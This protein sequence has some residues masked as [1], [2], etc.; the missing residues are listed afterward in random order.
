MAETPE[1]RVYA[2]SSFLISLYSP[3]ANSTA[4]I[5]A[6]Q[7]S[8]GRILIT[9]LVKLEVINA[10]QQRVFWK[11]IE[12]REARQSLAKFEENLSDGAFGFVHV[13]GDAF[14]RAE[15][16]A[17]RTTARLGTRTI[18]LLHVACALELGATH[19]Y[20]FDERQRK[21]AQTMRLKL[22]RFRP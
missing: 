5:A 14:D 22:N 19:L 1:D 10:L 18:D 7:T 8:T 20:S 4:A 11:Q 21:L 2:E 12:D 16:I 17:E 3:D 9:N 13:P 6:M 15:A